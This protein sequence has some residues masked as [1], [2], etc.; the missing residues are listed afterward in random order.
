MPAAPPAAD[1]RHRR[2]Y[3]RGRLTDW[4][5]DRLDAGE[6]LPAVGPQRLLARL[7]PRTF[8]AIDGRGGAVVL[9]NCGDAN[10][11]HL[12]HLARMT[13]RHPAFVAP[14]GIIEADDS[15]WA[16]SLKVGGPTLAEIIAARGRWEPADAVTLAR[17]LAAGLA[18][19]E[20]AGV[21]HGEIHARNVRLTGAGPALVDGGLA[22]LLD[23]VDGD[24]SRGGWAEL[25]DGPAEFSTAA[26][27]RAFAATVWGVLAGRPPFLLT[28]PRLG[29]VD[30]SRPAVPPIRGLAPDTPEPLA[31]L[32]DS[33]LCGGGEPP[34]SFSEVVRRL[35]P[36]RPKASPVR[37]AAW[38][39]ACGVAGAG[40][41]G[42]ASVPDGLARE[43]T[44]SSDAKPR[45]VSAEASAA[46]AAPPVR[47]VA[48]PGSGR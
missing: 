25:P 8:A 35:T 32:L 18:A 33:L 16:V 38:L 11:D 15:T 37:S 6:E 19:A 29:T 31:D 24:R 28:P 7:G 1:L 48:V 41:L 36:P 46:P 43:A 39:L 14:R 47:R 40:I 9:K 45:A 21:L 23:S 17:T 2:D 27:L 30:A 22:P 10:R 4:Q 44:F 34:A 3:L 26:D 13:V 12:A 5:R 42:A 20:A